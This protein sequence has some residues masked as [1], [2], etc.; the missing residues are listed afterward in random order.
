[1]FK[2]GVFIV[3]V[4]KC[5]TTS[6]FDVLAQHTQISPAGHK[7]PQFFCMSAPAV[8]KNSGWYASLFKNPEKLMLDGS[9]LYYQYPRSYQ[10][11]QQHFEKAK[12]IVCLR[13]PA[14]RF[15]SA[16]WHI[17]AKPQAIEKRTLA[18]VLESIEAASCDAV[19]QRENEALLTAAK[20]GKIDIS[21]LDSNYHYKDMMAQVKTE[22]LDPLAF[23]EYYKES[24]YSLNFEAFKKQADTHIVIFEKLMRDPAGELKKV[25]DFLGLEVEEATADLRENINQ[26]MNADG[27][28]IMKM[29]GNTKAFIFFKSVLGG[30]IKYKIK[31]LLYKPAP[32]I[33]KDEYDAIRAL[34]KE[35]YDYWFQLY[36]E[37]Q[38]LWKF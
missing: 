26:T 10:A 27:S 31:K 19:I 25:H 14:K 12:F 9:T 16:Y 6:L 24:V 33:T 11:I 4:R 35:E 37:L 28:S 5:G 29:L 20:Q 13:D 34:L 15:Y 3:G 22:G 18:E 21:Y 32:K 17:K 38:Q 2:N 8:D 1:M 36:P 23:Y 7:E 30:G